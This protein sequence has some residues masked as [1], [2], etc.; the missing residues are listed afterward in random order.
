VVSAFARGNP[1]GAVVFSADGRLL[2]TGSGVFDVAT[3]K[4]IT[5]LKPAGS[6]V[7]LSPNARLLAVGTTDDFGITGSVRVFESATGREVSRLAFYGYVKAVVF[8]PDGKLVAAAS[9]DHTV[10]VF[11]AA[12]GREISRLTHGGSVNAVEFS[13]DGKLMVTGSNDSTARVFESATG[14]EIT[15]IANESP[16]TSVAFSPD[17]KLMALG[18]SDGPARLFE[19]VTGPAISRPSYEGLVTEVAFSPDG[20]LAVTGLRDGPARV[21]DASTGREISRLGDDRETRVAFSPD[22]KLVAA[23]PWDG[24]LRIFDARSGHETSRILRQHDVSAVAFSL[25]GRFV[26]SASPAVGTAA[27]YEVATGQ[28]T[29]ELS[30]AEADALA[31]APDSKL[32]AVGGNSVEHTTQLFEAA[33]GRKVVSNLSGGGFVLGAAFSSDGKFLVV[34]TEDWLHLYRRDGDHWRPAGNRHV[35]VMWS[36]TVRFLPPEARCPRC[37]EVVRD[38]PENPL[39]LDR[40]SFDEPVQLTDNDP[41][42]LVEK[43]GARLGLAFDSRGRLNILDYTSQAR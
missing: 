41:R 37:V 31:F 21:F 26:A 19:V 20:K 39:K 38:S 4:E 28:E 9:N 17:G 2:A 36:N 12:T 24:P 5:Q 29:A 10:R 22:G 35:P 18:T 16:V 42:S 6:P 8:S 14:R 27:M 32:F 34:E 7:A 23:S 43:W 40:V 33:A 25:N 15:C 13:P 30:H 3:G 11:E 1:V